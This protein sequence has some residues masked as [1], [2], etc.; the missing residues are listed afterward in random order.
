MHVLQVIVEKSSSNVIMHV[1]HTA[2][3]ASSHPAIPYIVIIRRQ[4]Q[5]PFGL[6]FGTVADII[7]CSKDKLMENDPFWLMCEP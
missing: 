5:E 1:T 2:Y 6:D 7:A 3:Y 4:F